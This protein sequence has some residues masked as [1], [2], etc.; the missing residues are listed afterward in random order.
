MKNKILL[1]AAAILFLSLPAARANNVAV[2]G[3]VLENKDLDAG[4]IDIKFNLSQDNTFSGTDG[5][6]QEFY[7]AIWVFVKYWVEGVNGETTGW[8]H[9]TLT[10]GGSISPVSGGKGAFARVGDNQVLR[11]NYREDGVPNT[12]EIKVTLCAIEMVY[13]PA[14]RFVYN[15]G[16]IGGSTFNNYGGGSQVTVL[17]AGDIPSGAASGWPNGYNAF[18]IAKYEVSQGQYADFLNMLSAAQAQARYPN[19]SANRCSLTFTSGNPYGSRYAASS[20]SRSMNQTSW[21]DVKAYASW[22]ALRPLTEME[23]EKAARGGGAGTIKYPWGNTEPSTSTYPFDGATFSQYYANYNSSAGGPVNVGHYLSGD[24]SR[25]NEQKGVSVYGVT[26]LAGNNWEHLIN[27]QWPQVPE[28]GDGTVMPPP[29]WPSVALGKGFRGGSWYNDSS[30]LRVSA[31]DSAG[32]SNADRSH[33]YG[34]RLCRT[35]P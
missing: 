29:S 10:S 19:T 28:N 13:I 12:A 1:L 3:V 23:F 32:N 6:G 7:D 16:S 25:T 33:N 4:T 27:C 15:A 30:Y 21:N 35:S 18:Y 20:P 9:A 5:N 24:I 2:S 34:V 22:C 8:S 11:W 14:G 31:R 17:S 26:D